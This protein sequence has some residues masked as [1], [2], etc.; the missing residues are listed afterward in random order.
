V[1]GD[2]IKKFREQSGLSV[3][4]L[5]DRIGISRSYLSLIENNQRTNMK[6]ELL[7][8]IAES[9]NIPVSKLLGEEDHEDIPIGYLHVAKEAQEN[10][11]SPDDVKFAIDWLIQA[12][13]RSDK[14]KKERDK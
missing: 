2:N 11:L 6:P 4:E 7:N 10:G 9:L 14:A 3:T 1:I 12:K 5:A 8:E 13:K